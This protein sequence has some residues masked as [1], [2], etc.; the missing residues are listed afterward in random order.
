MSQSFFP[1]PVAA[2]IAS[3]IGFITATDIISAEEE[4]EMIYL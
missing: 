4:N 2:L 1:A 3:M